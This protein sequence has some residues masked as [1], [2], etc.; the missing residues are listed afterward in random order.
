MNV[1]GIE[2]D[3]RE[4]FGDIVAIRRSGRS[5]D[6]HP[7]GIAHFLRLVVVLNGAGGLLISRSAALSSGLLDF[8]EELQFVR[9]NPLP[10]FEILASYEAT[11]RRHQ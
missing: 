4:Q 10:T 7:G 5:P 6:H 2:L 8:D 3:Q 9:P 11:P 1:K